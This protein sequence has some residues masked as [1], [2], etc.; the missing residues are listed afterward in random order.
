MRRVKAANS[1]KGAHSTSLRAGSA[2][3][4]PRLRLDDGAQRQLLQVHELRK[5]EWVLVKGCVADLH[6]S[7]LFGPYAG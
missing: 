5:H 2:P 1:G 3:L 4:V 7:E 6:V